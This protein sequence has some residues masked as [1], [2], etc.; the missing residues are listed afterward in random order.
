MGTLT[1]KMARHPLPSRSAE[2]SAPPSS[3]P[4]TAPADSA[5]AYRPIA[6]TRAGPVNASW[7]PVSVWGNISAAP[8]PCST[9]AAMSTAGVGARPDS[10]E[11]PVKT[12]IP[13]RN[14]RR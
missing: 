2:I 14:M 1:R 10:A 7:M 3:C 9:R 5:I 8:A 12:A 6:R 11:A 4:A 13:A